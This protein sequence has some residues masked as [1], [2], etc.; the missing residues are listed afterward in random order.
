[1][2]FF[3]ALSRKFAIMGT[4]R[5]HEGENMRKV[6]LTVME[7]RCRGG[8]LKEGDTFLVEDLCPPICHEFWNTMYPF[9]YALLNGADLDH[10]TSRAKAFDA[11][12]PDGGRV[13]IHGEVIE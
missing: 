13:C 4:S 10:G 8:Y 5:M 6:K 1:M 7:S 2:A 12:C 3:I 9:V 11:R